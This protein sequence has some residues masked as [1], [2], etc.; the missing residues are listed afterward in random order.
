M[1]M[2]MI[3]ERRKSKLIFVVTTFSTSLNHWR[4]D[5]CP[6]G[7]KS[8]AASEGVCHLT[9]PQAKATSVQALNAAASAGS[10]GK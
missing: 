3:H 1:T 9:P 7:G 10:K 8:S 6:L 2:T 5:M 4:C